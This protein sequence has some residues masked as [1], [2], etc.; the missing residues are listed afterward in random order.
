MFKYK[1]VNKI[2]MMPVEI[3]KRAL[4]DPRLDIEVFIPS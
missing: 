2:N 4:K 3:F 1:E